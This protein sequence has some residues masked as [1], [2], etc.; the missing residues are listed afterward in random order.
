MSY[1]KIRLLRCV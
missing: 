1:S